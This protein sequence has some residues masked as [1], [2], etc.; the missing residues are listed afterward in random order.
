MA[1]N[2]SSY[3]SIKYL[4]GLG[5]D[6]VE[7]FYQSAFVIEDQFFGS[8]R[9]FELTLK[10]VCAIAHLAL[11]CSLDLAQS[12]PPVTAQGHPRDRLKSQRER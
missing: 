1:V 11:V 9:Q 6:V 5:D 3:P 4:P 2:L 7:R 10:Q 12:S 8:M